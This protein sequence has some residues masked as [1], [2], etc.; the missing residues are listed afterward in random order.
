VAPAPTSAPP[1][2]GGGSVEAL[3]E[4]LTR[5][6]AY[7]AHS[8]GGVTFSGGEATLFPA[9]LGA[10]AARLK[11]DGISLCLETCGHFP[12]AAIARQVLPFL[13]LILFDVKV[14]EAR[15]HR[16]VTG[17]APDL[18]WENL[19]RLSREPGVRVQPRVPVI[20]GLTADP[21]NLAA[22]RARVLA[23]GLPAPILL[24]ENPVWRHRRDRQA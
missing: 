6:R 20:P 5:D 17:V 7:Y 19:A 21:G 14:A 12:Y 24:R 23:L 10:L 15:R 1:G 2:P 13:D 8:G 9:Y 22:L 16:E 18:I 4:I 3:A 11:A